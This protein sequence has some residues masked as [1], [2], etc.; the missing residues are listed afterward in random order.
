MYPSA[1]TVTPVE[2]TE[3]HR[4]TRLTTDDGLELHE[5]PWATGEIGYMRT[6]GAVASGKHQLPSSS[7]YFY[8]KELCR[9]WNC[10][11]LTDSSFDTAKSMITIYPSELRSALAC[12][13]VGLGSAVNHYL[14]QAN[15]Y[16]PT[17]SILSQHFIIV[18]EDWLPIDQVDWPFGSGKSWFW[19]FFYIFCSC[20]FYGVLWYVN[21]CCAC[22]RGL[23]WQL[24]VVHGEYRT[25]KPIQTVPGYDVCVVS[26]VRIWGNIIRTQSKT[27][28]ATDK[29]FST[30]QLEHK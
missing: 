7:C 12:N 21:I 17:Y 8:I 27:A 3:D 29:R 5:F 9:I 2:E 30:L 22:V 14:R 11:C 19:L 28:L 4:G 26:I 10:G 20:L 24:E 18:M 1:G 23:Y 16:V 15:N 13:A 25:C 6:A